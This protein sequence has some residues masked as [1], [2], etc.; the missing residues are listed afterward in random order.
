MDNNETLE[1]IELKG[2][3]SSAI[4]HRENHIHDYENSVLSL[5]AARTKS[6]KF[7]GL[8]RWHR[9]KH[10]HYPHEESVTQLVPLER[11]HNKSVSEDLFYQLCHHPPLFKEIQ[12]MT[13]NFKLDE[14]EVTIEARIKMTNLTSSIKSNLT[15]TRLKISNREVTGEGIQMLVEALRD[16]TTI[17]H[18]NL[19]EIKMSIDKF[20]QI[21]DVLR[22]DR[23]LRVP[24]VKHCISHFD[25]DVFTKEVKQLEITNPAL[26]IVYDSDLN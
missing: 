10:P 14:L 3:D 2:L 19:N 1:T 9:S 6:K 15:V 18:L 7:L 4:F 24:E 17:T 23:T 20:R 8:F 13:Q 25:C 5:S 12:E 16:N 21:F 22:T 11:N 26:K